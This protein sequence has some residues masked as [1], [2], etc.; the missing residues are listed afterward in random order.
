MSFQTAPLSSTPSGDTVDPESEEECEYLIEESFG[1]QTWF[2]I[3]TKGKKT[4]HRSSTAASSEGKKAARQVN[5]KSKDKRA[6][7]KAPAM[8]TPVTKKKMKSMD[9]EG[10][11]K[12]SKVNESMA[13]VNDQPRPVVSTTT[14]SKKQRQSKVEP[15]IDSLASAGATLIP[16]KHASHSRQARRQKRATETADENC[17]DLAAGGM[18]SDQLAVVEQSHSVARL[19]LAVVNAVQRLPSIKRRSK[20]INSKTNPLV[21]IR[22][23]DGQDS[24]ATNTFSEPCQGSTSPNTPSNG[25]VGVEQTDGF[26]KRSVVSSAQRSS[27]SKRGRKQKPMTTKSSEKPTGPQRNNVVGSSVRTKKR[28]TRVLVSEDSSESEAGEGPY[29]KGANNTHEQR[30]LT[31]LSKTPMQQHQNLSRTSFVSPEANDCG[32]PSLQEASGGRYTAAKRLN[33]SSKQQNSKTLS[34]R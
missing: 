10:S 20:Q 33:R 19:P 14:K 6:L 22:N 32:C 12:V 15:A 13:V 8:P 23:E 17:Q 30:Q 24:T 16:K 18:H 3:P 11:L 2:S 5:V 9:C 31:E 1:T 25:S 7:K 28:T 27:R 21:E 29:G 4:E 26:S 34:L